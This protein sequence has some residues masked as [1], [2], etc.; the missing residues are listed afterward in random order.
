MTDAAPNPL[1]DPAAPPRFPAITAEH[2]V[3]GMRGLLAELGAD[4]D[5][6]EAAATP[7]WD[8]VVEPITRITDRLA[9]AWG[10]VGH[11]MAVRN[12][13]ALRA[14]HA[15][16][17]PEVVAFY[18]RLGQSRPLYRALK[19]LQAGDDWT[20]ADAAQRRIVEWLVRDAELGGVGLEGE[21][22][23]RFN[24][25]QTELAELS[26][27]FSN[28]VLDATKAWA[29]VLRSPDEVE[30]LVPSLRELAAQAA[31]EAGE[32]GATADA[33][34]WRLTLEA[35]S[36]VP[37]MQQSR[38]RDLRERLYRAFV[39]RASTGEH[40]NTPLI[41]RILGL[42]REQAALLGF[43]SYAALS[44]ATKMAPDVAAVEGLLEELRT[45]SWDAAHRDLDDLRT[46]AREA[47]AP[48]AED[49]KPWDVAFWAER[50]RERRYA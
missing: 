8:A 31:A 37:F 3:P 50:L 20:G 26:T 14:A 40:D 29:L 7:S 36:Y 30:G 13:E 5:G 24:A 16:V 1:L 6:L 49:M 22:Q 15:T 33:G 10:T 32:P 19:A 46:L 34:P 41:E 23:A 43:A 25:I 2:V 18:I 17:Q 9:L 11:L 44:L 27:R 39:T 42:R 45:A 48:E 35:P 12:E 47:A 21:A 28:H 4:L 38:R